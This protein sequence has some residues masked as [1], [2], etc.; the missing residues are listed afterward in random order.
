MIEL[1]VNLADATG[2]SDSELEDNATVVL[3]RGLGVLEVP[4]G[5][6]YQVTDELYIGITGKLM[7]GR[8]Y[9]NAVLVY[10]DDASDAFQEFD[11]FYEETTTASVDVGIL[12]HRDWF[13]IGAT[14][15]NLT[16]PSFDGLT[17]ERDA[18]GD[19]IISDFE[20]Y[21]V[22]DIDIDPQV[23]VGVAVTPLTWL[24]LAA[25]YDLLEV[26]T[27]LASYDSQLIKV[28]AEAE[29]LRTLTIRGGFYDNLTADDR[30]PVVTAG[31]GID[32]YFVEMDISGAYAL[33]DT[34][35]YDGED[36]PQEARIAFSL[37]S[38]Y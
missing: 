18:N 11:E 7:F 13:R 20:R 6:G 37:T 26:D 30:D 2:A 1:L 3:M 28:G 23:T 10:D 9:G 35:E 32:L 21:Q 17:I 5:Y 31:V 16:K 25:D 19:G 15:R 14:G 38:W 12:W 34:V 36:Y 27:V 29:L 33:G 22:G 24:T 8:V 4:I